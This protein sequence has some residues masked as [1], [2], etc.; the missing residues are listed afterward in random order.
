MFTSFSLYQLRG[1]L[2]AC[3]C[4][5]ILGLLVTPARAEADAAI[6]ILWDD[7]GAAA[8]SPEADLGARFKPRSPLTPPPIAALPPEADQPDATAPTIAVLPEDWW[9]Q[10]S[11]SPVAVALGAAEGTRRPDGG[12][13]PAYYWHTDP[14]NGANNFGTFS[15]QH[16]SPAQTESVRRARSAAAKRDISASLGLAESADRA[17]FARVGLFHDRLRDRAKQ[18]EIALTRRELLN[19]M[20]LANQSPLAGLSPMGYIDRLAQ[21]RSRFS[22]ADEQILEARVWSFWHPQRNRWDAPGLGNTYESIRHDQ[23]RR[24]AAIDA[25]LASYLNSVTAN[26][27]VDDRADTEAAPGI[28]IEGNTADSDVALTF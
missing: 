13:N 25:A 26:A 9:S 28:K 2:A 24:M 3:G 22:D 21:M 4:A 17:A 20:D 5:A 8:A 14:G 11:A 7:R 15:W 16:L 18:R 27:A 23:A 12:K 19:G 10:G 1:L 6:D